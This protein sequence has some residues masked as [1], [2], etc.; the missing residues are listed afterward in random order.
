MRFQL[1]VLGEKSGR[2]V[3]ESIHTNSRLVTFDLKEIQRVRQSVFTDKVDFA[4]VVS[5]LRVSYIIVQGDINVH[6]SEN[7][8]V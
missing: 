8:F 4:T 5:E 3:L 2:L 6:P 7:G 1:W